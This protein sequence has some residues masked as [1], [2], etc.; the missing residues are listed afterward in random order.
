MFRDEGGPRVCDGGGGRWGR[1]RGGGWV[2]SRDE[3]APA[4]N[5][6]ACRLAASAVDARGAGANDDAGRDAHL[7]R[8]N[9]SLRRGGSTSRS[10]GAR[11]IA[12]AV[13][14][15]RGRL[16]PPASRRGGCEAR[17]ASRLLVGG[18]SGDG[19][20]R[21]RARRRPWEGK[22]TRYAE[23]RTRG[24]MKH[25]RRARASI[26]ARHSRARPVPTDRA[27]SKGTLNLKS[28]QLQARSV[29]R[30]RRVR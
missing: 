14:P 4:R 1:R 6:D 19:S 30:T 16:E 5:R 9:E 10:R 7:A 17:D 18:N 27:R 15:M 20:V 24:G 12:F 3:T 8:T 26:C 13:F 25:A 28:I 11:G 22:E 23:T 29:G 2:S 21:P